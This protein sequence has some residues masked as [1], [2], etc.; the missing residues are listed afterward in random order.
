MSATVTPDTR[1]FS[2]APVDQALA[3][4]IQKKID[5]KLKPPGSLGRLEELALQL[6]LIQSSDRLT[7]N[8]PT[9]LLFAGDHG[10]ASQGVSIA[11]SD[12]T[13]LMVSSFLSGGAGIN[14][15]CRTNGM[16]LRLVDAGIQI[17]LPDHPHLIK[18][19]LGAGT[20]DFSQVA[21]MSIEAVQDG[22]QLGAAQVDALYAEGCNTVAFGEMGIGNTSSA[23]AIL[24][25]VTGC[26]V[27]EAVGRG[28][29]INDEQLARKQALIEQALELHKDSLNTPEEILAAV[30]GFEVVQVVGAMLKAAEQGMMILVDGFIISAAAMLAQAMFPATRDYMIFCHQSNEQGH[31][32]ML[33]ALQ[34]K[35]LLNLGMRL[36]EGSGTAVALSIVRSA[37]DFYND[38]ASF[39]DMGISL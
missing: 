4:A 14:S 35:P 15:L 37:C 39:E 18:Q 11:P 8:Q 9:L 13:T 7:I 12:V 31:Q 21:A 2:P 38:M 10:I 25:A 32:K 19:R 1:R 20:G 36:G 6:A 30:G 16:G 26:S 34:A 23:A 28:T 24:A 22:L 17:E 5:G 3:P 27:A 29:G 33:D